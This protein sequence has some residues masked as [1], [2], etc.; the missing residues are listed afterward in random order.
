MVSP[1]PTP[2]AAADALGDNP[3]TAYEENA[4]RFLGDGPPVLD[5]SGAGT[6]V[7][8]SRTPSYSYEPP[9]VPRTWGES[10]H[11]WLSSNPA[12]DSAS[13]ELHMY[14]KHTPYFVHA[15]PG[16]AA[17]YTGTESLSE[18]WK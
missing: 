7:P 8:L 9:S 4:A 5:D 12:K 10:F 2:D 14:R 11:T 15:S 1:N 16:N 17:M 3:V 6:S 18:L 13:A